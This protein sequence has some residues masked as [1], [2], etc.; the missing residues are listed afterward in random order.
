M[1]PKNYFVVIFKCVKI[2]NLQSL[3]TPV[4]NRSG[5]DR[6]VVREGPGQEGRQGGARTG[7][8]GGGGQTVKLHLEEAVRHS[9]H[10]EDLITVILRG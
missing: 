7:G 8:S 4:Y 2:S 1:I 6:R 3:S 5:P 10:R 9:A